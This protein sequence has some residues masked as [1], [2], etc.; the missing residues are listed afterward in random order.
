MEF[1]SLFLF[2]IHNK[3]TGTLGAHYLDIL[4][5]RAVGLYSY[6]LASEGHACGPKHVQGIFAALS[7]RSSNCHSIMLPLPVSLHLG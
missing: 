7:R 2:Q 1:V 4:N 3:H 5:V 6:H